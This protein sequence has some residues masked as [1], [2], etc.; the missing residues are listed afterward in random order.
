M[1]CLN[2]AGGPGA[3]IA[4]VIDTDAGT[5]ISHAASNLRTTG[6]DPAAAVVRSAGDRASHSSRAPVGA[7]D[8]QGQL[9]WTVKA[10]GDSIKVLDRRPATLSPTSPSPRSTT[11]SQWRSRPSTA[12]C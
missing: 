12:R 6:I 5:V 4:W 3:V 8:D 10:A 2:E 9:T 7:V 11:R 1:L